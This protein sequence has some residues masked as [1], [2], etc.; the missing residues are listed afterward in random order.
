MTGTRGPLRKP[1]AL[2]VIEGNAGKRPLNLADGVNP[3]IEIPSMPKHLAG[4]ARKEWRRITPLLEELG[5]IG[6]I[7]MGALSL[8]CSTYGRLVNLETA[9]NA[10]VATKESEGM[11]PDEAVLAI[12]TATTPSGFVQSSVLHQLLT[13]T[14]AEVHRY[15]AHFGL[16]PATRARVTPSNAVQL[17][18]PGM[19]QPKQ[20]TGFARFAG[21]G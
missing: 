19:E 6:A 21:G 10:R 4:P 11:T 1:L 15:L 20:A 9:F 12:S 5:L 8:Y 18:L 13:S 7:D 17:G 3:D 16:S 2:R 14:R